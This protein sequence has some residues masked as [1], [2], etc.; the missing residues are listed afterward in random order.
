MSDY[1]VP[2]Y[3]NNVFDI[4]SSLFVDYHEVMG[5]LNASHFVNFY[6]SY[7]SFKVIYIY[8]GSYFKPCPKAYMSV[9]YCSYFAV[10]H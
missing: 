3:F 10:V 7:F 9:M 1:V 2:S 6:R 4:I 5:H 8:M